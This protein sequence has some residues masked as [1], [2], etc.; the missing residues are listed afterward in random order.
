MITK[1]L[2]P[3]LF[4]VSNCGYSQISPENKLLT[5]V[6]TTLVNNQ[7]SPELFKAEYAGGYSNG[8]FKSSDGKM[9]NSFRQSIFTVSVFPAALIKKSKTQLYMGLGYIDQRFSG[10]TTDSLTSLFSKNIKSAYLG[11]ALNVKLGNHFFWLSYLQTGFNGTQPMEKINKTFNAVLISKADFKLQ[12]NLNLGVGIAYFSN[13]GNP[14]V[15]PAV[16]LTYSQPNYLINF[17]F[18]VKTEIE[19]IFAGGKIR[20][21]AG[22]SYHGG[23]YYLN[24]TDQYLYNFGA[25][26]Y[27]GV[28]F[29]LLDFLYFYT[30][31]QTG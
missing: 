27:L 28:R 2:L 21:V 23:N 15:L 25:L 11:T 30:A 5:E 9:L 20:P 1:I 26:G 18:P 19:G 3:I 10:F 8:Q 4:F 16:S 14:L 24:K 13:M 31:Y 22:L 7:L 29:K 12:R 6:N 17:D